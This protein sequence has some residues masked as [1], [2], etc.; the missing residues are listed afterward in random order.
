VPAEGCSPGYW[1]NHPGSWAPTGFSPGQTLE[2]VFDV[3]NA[4]GLDNVSLRNALR[5]GGGSGTAGAA[6]ILLRAGVAALLNAAHPV[7]D[8]PRTTA[9]VIAAVN[10]ALAS[11]NRAQMLI[12]AASLD[13]D[14]NRGC[15]L[16]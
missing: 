1:K 13:I 11:G 9:S 6:R 3:P 10:A 12:L 4:L 16:S 2:S 5:F 15:P 8:Y 7:V 14:N